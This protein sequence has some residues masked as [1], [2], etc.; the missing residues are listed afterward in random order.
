MPPRNARSALLGLGA[1]GAGAVAGL[2]AAVALHTAQ[3]HVATWYCLAIGALVAAL[4]RLSQF[5]VADL[6]VP[7]HARHGGS[8]ETFEPPQLLSRY[9]RRLAAAARERRLFVSGLQPVLRELAAERVS[10]HHGIDLDDARQL[11]GEELW[12][13]MTTTDYDGPAP[14]T[15]QLQQMISSIEAL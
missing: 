7:Q 1:I 6:E 13:W 3:V 8:R 5:A 9:E 12:Q 14:T 11:L 2:I 10:L 15:R 4:L